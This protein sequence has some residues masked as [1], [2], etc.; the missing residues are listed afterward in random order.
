MAHELDRRAL[1]LLAVGHMLNDVNQGAVPALL[2]FL[3]A[4]RGFSYAAASGIVLAVTLISGI[5]QPL[6]GLYSDRRPLTW[7]I[8]LGMLLGGLGIALTGIVTEYWVMIVCMLVSGAGVAAF[9]PESYRFANYV[10]RDQ[11]ATGMSIFTVGGNLGFALGPILLTGAVVVFGLPGTLV[12]AVPAAIYAG[13]LALN[14][15]AIARFRPTRREIAVHAQTH[16][17]RWWAFARLVA[18]IVLRTMVQYGLLAFVPLFLNRVRLVPIAEANAALVLISVSGAL[19]S[20][21]AG[22]LADR[23]GH[24]RIL[25]LLLF[26]ITPVLLLFLSLSGLSSLVM[27]ALAGMATAASFSVAVV[28]GQTYS[29]SNLGVGSG[30][31]T[32]LAIGLGG[33]STPL[34]GRMADLVGLGPVL[35]LLAFIP[36]LAALIALTLPLPR[37]IPREPEIALDSIDIAP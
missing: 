14:L 15:K 16:P 24:R 33:L 8:P 22:Y 17:T 36:L 2:P 13:V 27:L 25:I 1:A 5:T 21:L 35:F 28:L 23:L 6:L 31:T 12:L 9:H 10:S 26:V 19:G 34:L 7:L 32:G 11:R 18:V 37:E 30:I 20:L 29:E 4:D 3:V